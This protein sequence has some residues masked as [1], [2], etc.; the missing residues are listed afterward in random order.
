[1]GRVGRSSRTRSIV[2]RLDSLGIQSAVVDP[3]GNRPEEGDFMAVMRRNAAALRQLAD[4]VSG[5]QGGRE[6]LREP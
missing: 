5:G 4:A 1:M 3:A 6:G 2:E